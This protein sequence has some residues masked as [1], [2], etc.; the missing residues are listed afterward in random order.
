MRTTIISIFVS[1]LSAATPLAF[2]LAPRI[3]SSRV[4]VASSKPEVVSEEIDIGHAKY[5]ADH[6]G[7]CSLE[8]I[9]EMR[10]GET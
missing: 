9:G 5:C 3:S 8:D 10:N 4:L 7:E 2:I 6:F 1:L